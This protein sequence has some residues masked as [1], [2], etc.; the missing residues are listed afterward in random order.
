MKKISI[1]I[2]TIIILNTNIFSSSAYG[3]IFR[4]MLN[5][6]SLSISQNKQVEV[7]LESYLGYDTSKIYLN[8]QTES[9]F[10]LNNVELNV[11][12]LYSHAISPYWDIQ[13]GVEYNK[14]EKSSD[15]WAV[16]GLK[17]ML[18]Y[19][20]ETKAQVLVNQK[21]D[22]SINISLKKNILFTQKLILDIGSN[23]S[24]NI[25]NDIQTKL[26]MNAKLKYILI[27]EFTPFVGISKNIE[28]NNNIND[29]EYLVG[30]SFF[31]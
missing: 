28:F 4:S 6:E 23:I 14:L 13:T 12:L 24:T 17:G 30:I 25:K 18:P 3:D 21:K 27:K 7:E 20:I 31:L 8:L 15:N 19:F 11:Q 5:V 16:I 9:D 26:N 29:I 22:I 2:C 1:I 10:K